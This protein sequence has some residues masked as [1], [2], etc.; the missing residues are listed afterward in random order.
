[1]VLGVPGLGIDQGPP[2][3]V[4]GSLVVNTAQAMRASL[5]ASATTAILVWRR[6]STACTQ[7]LRATVF[8]SS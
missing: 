8:C 5:L 6:E 2:G 1:M 7:R 4:I 3:G